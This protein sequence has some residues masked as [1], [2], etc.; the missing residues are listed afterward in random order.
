MPID[1]KS[2]FDRAG[3]T[4]VRR[5]QQCKAKIIVQVSAMSAATVSAN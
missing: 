3:Q 5:K 2:L 4:Y 1:L